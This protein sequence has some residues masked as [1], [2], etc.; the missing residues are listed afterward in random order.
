[1][2][3]KVVNKT[4][5]KRGRKR[6]TMEKE[7]FFIEIVRILL[8]TRFSLCGSFS[9]SPYFFLPSFVTLHVSPITARTLSFDKHQTHRHENNVIVRYGKRYLEFVVGYNPNSTQRFCCFS[10]AII[11][12]D[13]M[14]CFDSRQ[15]W[16]LHDSRGNHIKRECVYGERGIIKKKQ[17]RYNVVNL[18]K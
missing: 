13:I 8:H 11:I 2:D 15:R 5:S 14:Q 16:N 7:F 12:D 4:W 3:L 17:R 6:S 10:A 9:N 18:M 1:M